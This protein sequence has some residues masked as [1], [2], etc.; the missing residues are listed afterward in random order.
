MSIMQN[1]EEKSRKKT[2][3]KNKK[4]IEKGQ[5]EDKMIMQK[6]C[7]GGTECLHTIGLLL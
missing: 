3:S 4:N 5:M 1:R 6:N 7:L 2:K